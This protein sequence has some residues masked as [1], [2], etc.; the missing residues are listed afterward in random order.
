MKLDIDAIEVRASAASPGPWRSDGRPTNFSQNTSVESE[1]CRI[2]EMCSVAELDDDWVDV[3][4]YSDVTTDT[5]A[6][7]NADFIAHARED[8]PALIAYIREREQLEGGR[9]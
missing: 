5:K 4:G 3:P 8:I 9:E 1:R 6:E 2:A 7:A